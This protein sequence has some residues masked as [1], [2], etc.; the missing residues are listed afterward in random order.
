MNNEIVSTLNVESKFPHLVE[1]NAMPT[2]TEQ[3]IT[4]ATTKKEEKPKITDIFPDQEVYSG[5][6]QET[7]TRHPSQETPIR[8]TSVHRKSSGRI[9][10]IS[11]SQDPKSSRFLVRIIDARVGFQNIFRNNVKYIQPL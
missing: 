7:P 5:T 4:A 6:S 2:I 1:S 3:S 11:G 10:T 9:R 8:K